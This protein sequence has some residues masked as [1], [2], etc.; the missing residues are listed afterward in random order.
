MTTLGI[1][2]FVIIFLW[3]LNL[4]SKSRR[5]DAIGS[6]VSDLDERVKELEE[7]WD[8]FVGNGD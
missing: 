4:S 2:L 5:D 7:K 6:A 8:E 1:I 3:L